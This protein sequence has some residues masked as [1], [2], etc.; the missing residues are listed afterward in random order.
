MNADVD[1]HTALLKQALEQTPHFQ[2]HKFTEEYEELKN[3]C[4]YM[5]EEDIGG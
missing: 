5:S 4:W 3:I 1:E 2:H